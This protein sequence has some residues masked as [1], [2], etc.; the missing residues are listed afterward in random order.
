MS[1]LAIDNRDLII[2]LKGTLYQ[3]KTGAEHVT[4][5]PLPVVRRLVQTFFA[6]GLP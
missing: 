4:P 2:V 5:R 3:R 1:T 6:L